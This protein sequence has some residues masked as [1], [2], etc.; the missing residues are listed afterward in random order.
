MKYLYDTAENLVIS[1]QGHERRKLRQLSKKEDFHSDL[2][3]YELFEEF[4]ANSEFEWCSPEDIGA[5]TSAPILC[6]R[7]E[8]GNIIDAYGFMHYQVRSVQQDLMEDGKAV[9]TKG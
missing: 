7:D 9:F 4:L 5:L 8:N 2:I 6:I 3:L 1:T